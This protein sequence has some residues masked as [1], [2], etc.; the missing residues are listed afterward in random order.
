MMSN[1]QLAPSEDH[2]FFGQPRGLGTLFF[3]EMWERFSYYGMRAI[4]VLYMTHAILNENNPGMALTAETAGAIY[5]IYTGM[6]YLLAL[7]GG[8]IADRVMGQRNAVFL[9]GCIIAAGHFSMAVPYNGTF[10]LGLILIVLGTGLL[11][12]N[13]S[14]MVGDFYGQ[15]DPRRDAGFSIFYMGINLGA[16]LS[17]LICGYLGEE[18][19]WHYGFGAAGVGMLFGLI[20]YK[21]GAKYLGD[22]GLLKATPEA[23]RKDRRTLSIILAVLG[24]AILALTLAVWKGVVSISMTTVAGAMTYIIIG[25]AAIYLFYAAFLSG[26]TPVERKRIGVIA[27]LF[28]AAALFW[29]GF[30]QAGSSLNLFADRLTDMTVLGWDMPA[31]WLQ[32]ANA[33]FIIAFA[34]VFAWLWLFLAKRHL[35]P[36]SP[37]KFAVGLIFLGG[38]FVVMVFAA[39][40]TGYG[41]AADLDYKRVSV[42]WLLV[43]YLLH[44]FGEL[45]LSPVGLS[46]MTK[47]S[48]KRFV[49][50]MMGIWFMAAALG[51]VI[52]GQVAGQFEQLPLPQIFGTVT[53]TTAGVGLILLVF[54]KPIRKL[55]GGVH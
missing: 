6:V 2:S 28:L 44:T 10:F 35:E 30:E 39:L 24:A 18:V 21:L 51:N 9:G 25:V 3:T 46:T 43:T 50:Q 22:A 12:P 33:L 26:V 38:G 20:Q 13:I 31:S 23:Y 54:V 41:G 16:F 32:S 55:M 11:K 14:A 47:L 4:L 17:P 19:N 40:L 34:P 1:T 45:C 49:G 42:G 37:L 7:P 52:A 5:G 27:I 29:S 36:S 53:L 48:P 15:D 8:W